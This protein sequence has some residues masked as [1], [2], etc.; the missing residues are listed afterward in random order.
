MGEVK[1]GGIRFHT[2]GEVDPAEGTGYGVIGA[3]DAASAGIDW[4]CVSYCFPNKL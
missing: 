2:G 3:T 4:G 1:G